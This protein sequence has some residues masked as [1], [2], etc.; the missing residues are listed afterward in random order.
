M[1]N[2]ETFATNAELKPAHHGRELVPTGAALDAQK[3]LIIHLAP[4][5]IK[6]LILEGDYD[7]LEEALTM[8]YME[9]YVLNDFNGFAEYCDANEDDE[10]FMQ[11]VMNNSLTAADLEEMKIFIEGNSGLLFNNAA[12]IE[13]FIKENKQ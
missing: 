6:Q 5:E 3:K 11:R 4:I 1:H 9:K 8:R 10:L 2:H 12:E 13:E 7:S